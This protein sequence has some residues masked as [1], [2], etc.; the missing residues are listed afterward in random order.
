MSHA[1]DQ[2]VR[3]R[4]FHDAWADTIDPA[5]VRVVES[6]TGSTSPESQW[7]AAELGDVR[8]KRLLE[9]GSGAG[10]GA[11]YFALQGADAIA[12]DLSPGMLTVVEAVAAR[13]NTSVTTMVLSADDLSVIPSESIDIV[14][15][16]N[17]LHHV[18]IARC[19]DEIRRVLKPGGRAA[20]WDPI[21]YNPVINV[22]RRMASAVRTPDEHPIRRSDLQ[23]FRSR[24]SSIH[25]RFFWLTALVV[26]L[27]FYLI[28]RV[29]PS[30][31]RYWKR[32]ITLEPELRPLVN[33]LMRID[34]WLLRICPPLGLLCWNI[35]I[36]VRK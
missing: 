14:Y 2:A 24:F 3:E 32:V 1:I 23:L 15:A 35:A 30:K 21:A 16:A 18:D 12:T 19:L 29:D 8:G 11:V 22:Y 34:R 25:Y 10:E 9:L 33:R 7:I 31:D 4:E 17:L 28:D 13:H 20:F 26:F 36:V 6:F 5:T 27:K